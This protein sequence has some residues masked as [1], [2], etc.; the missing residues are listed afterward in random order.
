MT[1]GHCREGS[2]QSPRL[3]LLARRSWKSSAPYRATVRTSLRV[4]TLTFVLAGP[5]AFGWP[6]GI[7]PAL[8]N[9]SNK[10]RP[11]RVKV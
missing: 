5:A 8:T 11:L 7:F 2:E 6:C 1:T 9:L 10:Q 3:V 4:T